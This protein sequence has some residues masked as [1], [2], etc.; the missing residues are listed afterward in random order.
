MAGMQAASEKF[1]DLI[2]DGSASG[3]FKGLDQLITTCPVGQTFSVASTGGVGALGDLSKAIRLNRGK[4]QKAFITDGATYDKIEGVLQSNSTL[5][6]QDLFGGAFNTI[7]YRGVPVV[8]N[9]AITSG[10]VYLATLGGDGVDVVFNE[11]AERKVGGVFDY[12]EI[13]QGLSSINEYRRF[14][15]RATQVLKNPLSLVKISNFG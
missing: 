2:I 11:S 7:S 12:I 14:I 6:Y 13:P 1:E 10:N 4:G 5:G 15:W 8:V 9:D 3:K